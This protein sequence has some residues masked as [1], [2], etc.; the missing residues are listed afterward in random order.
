MIYIKIIH[1]ILVT[2]LEIE[3]GLILVDNDTKINKTLV[4]LRKFEIDSK[5]DIET[6]NKILKNKNFFD[7]NSTDTI[8][9]Q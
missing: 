4:Y 2:A 6:K 5:I 8:E 1:W 9:L 3:N 7:K